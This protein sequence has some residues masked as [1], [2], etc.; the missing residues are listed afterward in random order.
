M[1]KSLF[2]A[3]FALLILGLASSVMA[4]DMKIALV[5]KN[6]GN[7][8]FEAC[9]RG[10]EE[11]AKEL[12][13]IEIIYTGPT[14]PT[15]EGQIEI[16]RSLTAQKVDGI[17]VSANDPD[18]LVTIT[19]KAMKRGI[20]VMS[21]DSAIAEAG[22]II[23]MSPSDSKFIGEQQVELM[24]QAMDY[25]GEFAIVSASSQATNQNEW[26]G[27]MKEA[28]EKNPKYKDMKLVAVTYGDDQTDKSYREAQALIRKYP[29]LK[30]IEAPTS[31]GFPASAKAVI[32]EG[33]VG[34]IFVTGLGLPSEVAGYVKK[35]VVKNFALWNPVDLGYT[36]VFIMKDLIDK[37]ITGKN[38]EA[39]TAG[40]MGEIPVHDAGQMVMG[41]P[42]VFNADNID[43]WSSVF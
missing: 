12:G 26:I 30:G 16:I 15:A 36:S 42:F 6:L 32:D 31:V 34:K 37:K 19:K 9:N 24:G 5:V 4:K 8:F 14:T 35:G 27:Y 39:V 41:A 17:I 29:N 20:P 28:L 40:R 23:H 10:A 7:G 43:D 3:F 18:S 33:K 38:G 1:R 21:F 13:D 22:R 11:A 2:T 25:K